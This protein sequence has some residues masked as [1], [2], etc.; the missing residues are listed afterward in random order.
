MAKY[1]VTAAGFDGGSDATDHLVFWIESFMDPKALYEYL[2]AR[3]IQSPTRELV[4]LDAGLESDY[5]IPAETGRLQQALAFDHVTPKVA[6]ALVQFKQFCVKEEGKLGT[7]AVLHQ[8]HTSLV[9]LIEDEGGDEVALAAAK[10]ML[11]WSTK[12]VP[13]SEAGLMA[14][15]NQEESGEPLY[16]LLPETLPA[17]PWNAPS[18][19]VYAADGKMVCS[20]G[21][22]DVVKAYRARGDG[23]GEQLMAAAKAVAAVPFLVSALADLIDQVRADTVSDAYLADLEATLMAIGRPAP[24]P[25]GPMTVVMH[26]TETMPGW[27]LPLMD[28]GYTISWRNLARGETEWLIK[29]GKAHLTLVNKASVKCRNRLDMV[30]EG[31][32]QILDD[33]VELGMVVI[34]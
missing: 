30:T 20:L 32:R 9:A 17:G 13:P 12:G 1:E 22:S 24:T 3:G 4:P 34:Q 2:V 16:G 18:A 19:A 27:N 6:E 25:G 33:L 5:E 7:A 21:N 31:Q 23:A 11:D 29:K 26:G 14:A 8:S 15:A 28:K 10:E